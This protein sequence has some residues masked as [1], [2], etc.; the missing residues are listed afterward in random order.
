MDFF[1]SNAWAQDAA[2][3]P[4]L[5][6]TFLPLILLAVIFYFLLVRPQLK[7]AKEH[8]ALVAAL[9]KG[10]E[11]STSG[12]IMGRITDLG[13]THVEVEIADNVTIKM[14]REA[15]VAIL[16]KGSIKSL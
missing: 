3:E 8:R 2:S 6:A 15:V 7:R 1:I 5:I 12:G 16:P 9:S 14:Q 10:D 4:S 13:E 11:V